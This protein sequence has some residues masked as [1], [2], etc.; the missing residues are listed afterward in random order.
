[1]TEDNYPIRINKYLAKEKYATR[2]GA[3][4]LITQGKVK[5]N[6]QIAKLGDKVNLGDQV[7]VINHRPKNYRYYI[8]YKPV[9]VITHSP[10]KSEKDIK[11]FIPLKGLFPV[12]RL[13]KNSEGLI[14]LTDDG[15]VTE[16]LLS[17]ESGHEKEYLVRTNEPLKENLVNRMAKGVMIE[18]YIT[19][20][21][22]ATIVSDYE[23]K[24]ILTEGKK[25]Q[26]RR[27]CASLGYTVLNLKRIRILNLKLHNLAS[28]Q[29]M[30]IKKED[31][32]KFLSSI[33]L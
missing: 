18:G 1:M 7:E 19:K 32:K 21:A 10:Q 6:G 5:I 14:I 15:R 16:R 17:P 25:H 27:M 12:G 29:Y 20:P 26:I 30:E 13:D 22:Q 24:I 9:G 33:S 23:F 11:S 31:L 2:L 4:K 28:G 8:F 3:D